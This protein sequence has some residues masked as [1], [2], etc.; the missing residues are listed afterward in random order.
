MN[1]IL[2]VIAGPNGSGKTT[3][4]VR[5]RAERWSDGVEYLN[6][7]DVARD[8]FGNWNS[9]EASLDAARWT[10]SRREELLSRTEGIAFETVFSAN[11]KLDFVSR[12]KERGY[13][14]RVFFIGTVDPRI[15]AS[16]VA[17]RVMEGGH[18]VPIEKIVSRYGRSMANLS[19]VIPFADRVYIYDN[20][21]DGVEAR[22]C[23]RTSDGALRKVYGALPDWVADT[24]DPLPRHAEF[25]DMRGT[26]RTEQ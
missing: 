16:R 19:A 18:T 1:P 25:T 15:N 21:I 7:D 4:T 11:D 9:P 6:P 24:V 8:R 3:V 14:V 12:A 5:L 23:A 10:S 22:L 2:L 20:S 26:P 17:G 13:F